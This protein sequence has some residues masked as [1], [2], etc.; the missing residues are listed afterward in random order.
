MTASEV[1]AFVEHHLH[2]GDS[3]EKIE[4]F[5]EDQDWPYSYNR[6]RNRYSASYRVGDVDKWYRKRATAVWIYVDES[7][8]FE[9]VEVEYVYTGI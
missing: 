1:K 6:F 9:R 3:P 7:K 5:L 8:D 2:P 4:A